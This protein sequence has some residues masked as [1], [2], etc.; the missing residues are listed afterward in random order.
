MTGPA[1]E[2]QALFRAFSQ[3]SRHIDQTRRVN[4]NA[5]ALRTEPGDIAKR[6]FRETRPVLQNLG[7]EQEIEVRNDS[8]QNLL[9]LSDRSNAL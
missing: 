3:F 7:L 6:Y 9:E 2:C 5:I 1:D 4:I 8:F